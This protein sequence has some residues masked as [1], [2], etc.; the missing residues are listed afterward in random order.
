MLFEKGA[1]TSTFIRA[2][3][4]STYLRKLRYFEIY[5][6]I[7]FYWVV[8]LFVEKVIFRDHL[9]ESHPIEDALVWAFSINI[10]FV[11]R[12]LI[13]EIEASSFAHAL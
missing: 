7:L 9:S 8:S 10:C 4:P 12:K 13:A 6:T 3:L 5:L 11:V 1:S 2:P